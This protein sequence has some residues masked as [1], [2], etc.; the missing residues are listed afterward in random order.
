VATS[1]RPGTQKPSLT[2]KDRKDTRALHTTGERTAAGAPQ[3]RAPRHDHRPTYPMGPFKRLAP[4][5]LAVDPAR[6]ARPWPS[7]WHPP[8]ALGACAPARH[9]RRR[10]GHYRV[11]PSAR[12]RLQRQSRGLAFNPTSP[13]KRS[14]PRRQTTA[15]AQRLAKLSPRPKAPLPRRA[16]G[17]C[18]NRT[19]PTAASALSSLAIVRLINLGG[20]G[21]LISPSNDD[22]IR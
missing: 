16:A 17:G 5:A 8:R 12:R 6:A 19:Q 10:F 3:A 21:S 22:D 2:L 11:A 9:Q 7:R 1:E 13:S 14:K 18:A 20:R 15:P 4:V